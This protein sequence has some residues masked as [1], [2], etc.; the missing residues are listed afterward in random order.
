MTVLATIQANQDFAPTTAAA[1]IQADVLVLVLP[2]TNVLPTTTVQ[3]DQEF[4]GSA[5]LIQPTLQLVGQLAGFTATPPV[6]QSSWTVDDSD[7]GAIRIGDTEI[8]ADLEACS[9]TWSQTVL[10]GKGH[11]ATFEL[12]PLETE[13]TRGGPPP[14]PAVPVSFSMRLIGAGTTVDLPLLTRGYVTKSDREW[15]DEGHPMELSGSGPE[16]LYKDVEIDLELEANHGK[17]HGEIGIMAMELAGVPAGQIG[18][19]PALGTPRTLKQSFRCV[20]LWSFLKELFRPIGYT[21]MAGRTDDVFR[22]VAIEV[23]AGDVPVMTIG[24]RDV[25]SSAGVGTSADATVPH[26]IHIEGRRIEDSVTGPGSGTVTTRITITTT[27]PAFVPN[28]PVASQAAGSSGITPT[29]FGVPPAIPDVVVGETVVEVTTTDGCETL[30]YTRQRGFF[31]P[32]ASRYILAA[33]LTGELRGHPAFNVWFYG[34]I[35]DPDDEE[36]G[37]LWSEER[38]VTTS[39]VWVEPQYNAAGRR[40]GDITRTSGWQNIERALRD[41]G[42]LTGIW[43][44]QDVLAGPASAALQP[45]VFAFE[46]YFV[47]PGAPDDDLPAGTNSAYPGIPVVTRHTNVD[48][49]THDIDECDQITATT[50]RQTFYGK[51]KGATQQYASGETS[52]NDHLIGVSTSQTSQSVTIGTRIKNVN[53]STDIEGRQGRTTTRD[54]PAGRG[55]QAA[56]ICTPEQLAKDLEQR[57]DVER[58]IE[59]GDGKVIKLKPITLSSR[60]VETVKEAEFWGDLELAIAHGFPTALTLTSPNPTLDAGDVVEVD[61]PEAVGDKVMCKVIGVETSIP[62]DTGEDPIVHQVV[63][64]VPTGP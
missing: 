58:C 8:G 40:D 37:F 18:I 48:I 3:V 57:I 9:R 11:G 60:W 13:R 50:T 26:C 41:R 33:T 38:F 4:D 1:R 49:V 44:E 45:Q 42:T 12:G 32:Q 7:P 10:A 14:G 17:T 21:V 63:V 36:E 20:G 30:T 53:T 34:G 5:P 19:D 56:E 6:Y 62:P 35:P 25:E 46:H 61:L 52:R 28:L 55:L 16:V 24:V 2:T 54:E 51:R 23:R 59:R 29:G 39:E 22:A 47:G 15:T 43:E 31:K 64:R 27:D